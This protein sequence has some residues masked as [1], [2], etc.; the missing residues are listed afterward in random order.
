MTTG[1][2]AAQC[3]HASELALELMGGCR[4]AIWG[5]A[6]FPV[7]VRFPSPA[8]WRA[9]QAEAPVEVRDAGHTEVRPGTPTV[10][11]TWR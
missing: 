8:A 5:A 9:L 3:G 1:K 6:G 4:A 7:D 11:A 10:R 2:A